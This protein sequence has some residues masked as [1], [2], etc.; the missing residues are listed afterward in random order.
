MGSSVCFGKTSD[1][2]SFRPHCGLWPRESR[3]PEAGFQCRK[4]QRVGC[5]VW[6]VY[7][8]SH[9]VQLNG[10]YY[11]KNKGVN[12]EARETIRLA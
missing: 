3:E 2:N 7:C 1:F 11:P 10:M 6:S 8:F 4:L 12:M 9:L 5:K